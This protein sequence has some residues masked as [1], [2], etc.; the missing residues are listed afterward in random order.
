MQPT[1]S[2][3]GSVRFLRNVFWLALGQGGRVAA[4]LI[5][6]IFVARYLGTERFGQL[7]FAVALV[8]VLAA[9]TG[10]AL[11]RLLLRTLSQHPDATE[12][13]LGSALCLRLMGGL[14]TAALVLTATPWLGLDTI[15]MSLVFITLTGSVLSFP[16]IV[17]SYFSAQLQSRP[18][19][20]IATLCLWLVT[21]V[22]LWLVTL[23]TEVHCFAMADS[24]GQIATAL[25]VFA[26]F[27]SR[28][29][30]SLSPRRGWL[31]ALAK[32]VRPMVFIGL[33]YAVLLRV[34]Q[35]MLGKMIGPEAL[36]TYLAGI[37]FVDLLLF[38]P[39]LIAT[40]II[41]A[42][43]RA[44]ARS[45]EQVQERIKL[46][47]AYLA[48]AA[49]PLSLGLSLS[50]YWLVPTLYGEAFLGSVAVLQIHAWGLLFSFVE[51]GR[52]QWSLA[53][54]QEHY[55]VFL[56]STAVVIKVLLNLVL[57]PSYGPAGASVAML[58]TVICHSI[59]GPAL[60]NAGQR[61]Q[62]KL[63]LRALLLLDARW[64]WQT[65]NP[66][67]LLKRAPSGH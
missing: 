8:G 54:H 44:R 11:Q 17:G 16:G 49:W 42:L 15:T 30:L 32:Q 58:C 56:L 4:G 35:V 67:A 64:A 57:I 9:L 29:Q 66:L 40:S 46:V 61:E 45:S 31:L 43:V 7:G 25:L 39:G 18:L 48:M 51:A 50:A 59:I 27:K 33:I 41:P 5:S 36:G 6:T 37:K 65:A 21:L 22:K 62:V 53:H 47:Y 60:L 3:A 1:L 28:T 26:W 13:I 10:A 24:A 12:D 38:V 19:V 20:V 34:D 23:Q 55:Q 52:A 14:A 63:M 2:T